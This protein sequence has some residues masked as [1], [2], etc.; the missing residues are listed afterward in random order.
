M[1]IFQIM[2]WHDIPSQIKVVDDQNTVKKMLPNRFQQAIDSAAMA[3]GK[4]DSNIYL[5]GWAWG[6]KTE[7]SGTAEAVAEFLAI[8]LDEAF[9]K[10]KLREI[11]LKH[12]RKPVSSS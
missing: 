3:A 7:R 8:E 1:A 12:A 5:T 9:P 10:A 6:P 4:T 11:I 2:Y